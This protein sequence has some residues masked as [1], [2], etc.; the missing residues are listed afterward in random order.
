MWFLTDS[1]IPLGGAVLLLSPVDEEE[2]G[3]DE[4]HR[5]RHAPGQPDSDIRLRKS[6]RGD[7]FVVPRFVKSIAS[8]QRRRKRDQGVSQSWKAGRQQTDATQNARVKSISVFSPKKEYRHLRD[9]RVEQ[10]AREG[11]GGRSIQKN[12][13]RNRFRDSHSGFCFLIAFSTSFLAI[14][15]RVLGSHHC[16][17]VVVAAACLQCYGARNLWAGV[18]EVG[19]TAGSLRV[20]LSAW[21]ERRR[22][23]E[24]AEEIAIERDV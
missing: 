20:V 10:A 1:P 22:T 15:C 18:G 11:G 24:T 16:F 6:D 13:A 5:H 4:H 3:E 23:T 7:R 14:V 8:G 9:G 12:S 21:E 19:P 2:R 17:G